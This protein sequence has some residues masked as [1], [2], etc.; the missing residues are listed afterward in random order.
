MNESSENLPK[1]LPLPPVI[2]GI[3]LIIALTINHWFPFELWPNFFNLFFGILFLGIGVVLAILSFMEFKRYANPV[4]PFEP[5][6]TLM[7]TGPY[8]YSRNPLYLASSIG[9]LG[10]G[11]LL[12]NCWFMWTLF[13]VVF[14]MNHLVIAREETYLEEKFGPLYINYKAST[15][16]WI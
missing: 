9:Y 4:F 11:F 6:K 12:N 7:T 15:S 14:F 5:T 10:I 13:F 16:R 1:I 3:H 2:F 8:R